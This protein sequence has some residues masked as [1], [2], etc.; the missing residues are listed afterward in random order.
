MIEREISI[1][2]V[3]QTEKEE[4]EENSNDFH[5]DL[6]SASMYMCVWM[7][8]ECQWYKFVLIYVQ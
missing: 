8:E 1:R 6:H 3:G 2:T 7:C 4:E 5:K